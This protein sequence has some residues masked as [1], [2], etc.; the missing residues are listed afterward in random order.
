MLVFHSRCVDLRTPNPKIKI[1]MMMLHGVAPDS[2]IVACNVYVSEGRSKDILS[3]LLDCAVNRGGPSCCCR[4]VHV[5]C[6]TRYNRSSFH[7]VGS[8]LGIVSVVAPFCWEAWTTLERKA[9]MTAN[10]DTS[11]SSSSSP[12]SPSSFHHLR[13]ASNHPTVGYVDHVAVLPLTN[14]IGTVHANHRR[15]QGNDDEA[16]VTGITAMTI[17]QYLEAGDQSRGARVRVLYYGSACPNRTPLATVRRHQTNF[18]QQQHQQYQQQSTTTVTT[19]TSAAIES[20]PPSSVTIGAPGMF[21][22]NYNIRLRCDRATAR[23]LTK[24]LRTSLSIEALTLAYGS[25]GGGGG[26]SDDDT[27]TDANVYEVACNLTN[28]ATTVHDIEREVAAWR[29]ELRPALLAA[30][31]AVHILR[32]YRVGTTAL[33]CQQIWA[34]HEGD[35]ERHIAELRGS[36]L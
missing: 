21:V 23:T 28:A 2:T 13:S 24:R 17:G 27:T 25:S 14:T 11:S 12:P 29:A 10:A 22:E 16:N 3:R 8:T 1:S 31:P 32:Q 20:S 6:D 5:F 15:V 35:Y 26:G 36:V 4:L 9:R 33:Q 19:P 18:F 34:A 7:F 30:D